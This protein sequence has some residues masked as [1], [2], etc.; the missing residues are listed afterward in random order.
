VE[1]NRGLLIPGLAVPVSR[2]VF[3]LSED[4]FYLFDYTSSKP[5][6]KDR[7]NS[8]FFGD[9]DADYPDRVYAVRD[10]DQTRLYVLYPGSGNVGG[11]PNK[12]L[13][14]DWALDN[15]SHAEIDAE[16]LTWV[17]TPGLNLDSPH[18]PPDDPDQI[19]GE[20]VEELPPGNETFDVRQGASGAISIGAYDTSHFL[21]D[22]SG[23][24]L[25]GTLESGHVEMNP[26]SRTFVNEVR[27]IVDDADATIQIA[28][29]GRRNA[30]GV[31]GQISKQDD[32]GKCPV[33]IDG[34]Y[35]Q[36]RTNLPA[37]FN[38]AVGMDVGGRVSGRK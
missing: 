23:A 12:M 15:F 13:C 1:P 8:T 24:N 20:F 19:G 31:F 11:T 35:H 2:W 18:D 32:D 25:P 10:P 36:F 14:Y 38:N 21:S 29:T 37:T 4:G 33:R 7:I 3:Y 9:Y 17:V 27:P 34:R 22:F 5:I 6:G 16:V 30:T 26:G 28:A